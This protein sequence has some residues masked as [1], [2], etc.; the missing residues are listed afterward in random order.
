MIPFK[1]LIPLL[2]FIV[3]FSCKSQQYGSDHLP[4]KQLVFGKGGGFSGAEDAFSLLENGQLFQLSSL[5]NERR[6]LKGIKKKEAKSYFTQIYDLRLPETDFDHPGNVYYYLEVV[7]G[8]GKY[9]VTW[10]SNAHEVPE[11]Y[12]TLHKQ[13]MTITK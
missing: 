1:S 10:G 7:N 2:F 9:R 11:T 12:K 5:T 8:E 4:E 3:F 13:L 6:E